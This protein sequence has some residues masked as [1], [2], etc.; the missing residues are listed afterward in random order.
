MGII[1]I[2]TTDLVHLASPEHDHTVRLRDGRVLG[3]AEYGDPSGTPWFFFHGGGDCRRLIAPMSEA[4]E[5][6]GVR[7]IAPDRWG[8]SLSDPRP[9]AA[10][11]DWPDDMREPADSLGIG[12]FVVAG[13]GV[14]A[15][16]ALACAYR[17]PERLTATVVTELV[18]PGL[19][20]YIPGVLAWVPQYAPWIVAQLLK[21]RVRSLK[22]SPDRT[23][24]RRVDKAHGGTKAFYDQSGMQTFWQ[25]MQLEAYSR[26]TQA[27]A[28]EFKLCAR[29]WGFALNDVKAPVYLW[30]AA[31]DLAAANAARIVATSLPDCHATFVA[32]ADRLWILSNA[33]EVF[34][35]VRSPATS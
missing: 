20:G 31:N 16:F 27:V 30:Q 8:I 18:S 24:R 2:V 17:M 1:S 23:W 19:P 29:P 9:D 13:G 33:G 3:Y 14:G 26:G 7:I 4:A 6:N 5:T 21:L 35:A 12:K 10:L 25:G 34:A 28:Q 11:L 22:R 15:A 32:D